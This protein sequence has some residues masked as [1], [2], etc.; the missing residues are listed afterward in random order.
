MLL[1]M[2]VYNVIIDIEYYNMHRCVLYSPL[3]HSKRFTLHYL[4]DLFIPLAR[5]SLI[6]LSELR[7]TYRPTYA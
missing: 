3:A 4:V 7:L 5:Y 2:S 6:Q 1:F